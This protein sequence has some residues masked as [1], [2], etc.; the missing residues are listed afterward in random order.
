[1]QTTDS[2]K[3]RQRGQDRAQ[4]DGLIGAAREMRRQPT[5]TEQ[6][7]WEALRRKQ[8]GGMRFRR[9]RVI[10]PYIVDFCCLS[11]KLIVEVD[12]RHHHDPD[13]RAYDEDRTKYLEANGFR[14]LRFD[15]ADVMQ[16][17]EGVVGR[18]NPLSQASP[19]C[20]GERG[21]DDEWSI[22]P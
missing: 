7:L 18:I 13:F 8:A 5:V 22:A 11:H 21:D 3:P 14:V 1:M 17:V 20:G 19:L 15:N 4:R 16:D 9:Q 2:K 10:G 6:T 12:G